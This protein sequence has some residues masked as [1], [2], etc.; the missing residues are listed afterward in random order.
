MADST[1]KF[2]D[3]ANAATLDAAL[4][5]AKA[6][7][8][9]KVRV[10]DDK[11]PN[12]ID[13]KKALTAS[14]KGGITIKSDS[15]IQKYLKLSKSLKTDDK[16]PADSEMGSIWAAYKHENEK[17]Y[18]TQPV[19]RDKKGQVKTDKHG[20][21]KLKRGYKTT[22][23]DRK[24]INKEYHK[25]VGN[26]FASKFFKVFRWVAVAGITALATV[27]FPGIIVG[28]FGAVSPAL[29]SIAYIGS[30][31]AGL[32]GSHFT[33]GKFLGSQAEKYAE[34]ANEHKDGYLK[35]KQAARKIKLAQNES[36]DI[37]RFA[38]GYDL[39]KQYENDCQEALDRLQTFKETYGINSW[40]ELDDNISKMKQALVKKN[41][42][43]FNKL[44]DDCDE[45]IKN[46]KKSSGDII[47]I[48]FKDSDGKK[49]ECR[50]KEQAFTDDKGLT[51]THT[52]SKTGR[53]METPLLE[54]GNEVIITQIDGS[55]PV[56]KIR[57]TDDNGKVT[58]EPVNEDAAIKALIGAKQIPDFLTFKAEVSKKMT[59]MK[60]SAIASSCGI[61]SLHY[62]ISKSE[63]DNM[64]ALD[65]CVT[66]YFDQLKTQYANLMT[67]NKAKTDSGI[68]SLTYDKNKTIDE[69]IFDAGKKY[70]T[71]LKKS[72]DNTKNEALI[73]IKRHKLGSVGTIKLEIDK[74]KILDPKTGDESEINAANQALESLNEIYNSKEGTVKGKNSADKDVLIE[75][76]QPNNTGNDIEVPYVLTKEGGTKD[77][78]KHYINN[79]DSNERV[80]IITEDGNREVFNY[81]KKTDGK[82]T[83]MKL[84]TSRK[85]VLN[86]LD[87][88]KGKA[89]EDEDIK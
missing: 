53:T 24:E 45:A 10:G 16:I 34:R 79:I 52:G 8:K 83:N 81:F 15:D 78:T 25:Y 27:F 61:E 28:L 37:D 66:T 1:Y 14:T 9:A 19:K 71:E 63:K 40:K 64:A 43:E 70:I 68:E 11:E 6:Y 12:I 47:T 62:D 50:Y 31:A 35:E 23:P 26:N 22:D 39:S 33:V 2:E 86:N 5:V 29:L 41:F 84:T 20:N 77:T 67:N 42:D 32:A 75:I 57:K 17:I 38:E 30:A 54:K 89:A 65:N 55:D 13:I 87:K 51:Y 58:I 88:I 80:I 82:Y 48:E 7:N 60:D 3:I 74:L 56:V 85:D 73:L 4:R 36:G 72:F 59:E 44:K 69:Q 46:A 21:V 76:I 49:I 18:Q